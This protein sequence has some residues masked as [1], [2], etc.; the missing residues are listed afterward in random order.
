M[1]R[2]LNSLPQY[3]VYRGVCFW[4]A[5]LDITFL[6]MFPCVDSVLALP[7][8]LPGEPGSARPLRSRP[9]VTKRESPGSEP[10]SNGKSLPARTLH[11]Q[12]K[13]KFRSFV[14]STAS[15]SSSVTLPGTVW[16][17]NER[18]HCDDSSTRP[19]AGSRA[20]EPGF[21]VRRS[22]CSVLC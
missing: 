2:K 21:Y 1:S 6:S 20:A 14:L 15:A 7:P 8:P 3:M 18:P 17:C 12:H 22:V 11:S 9:R 4:T 13:D 10:R 19:S 5:S 16:S